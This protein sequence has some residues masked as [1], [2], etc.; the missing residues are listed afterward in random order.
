MA[1]DEGEGGEPE[2]LK[3]HLD[4]AQLET[5][6]E[7]TLAKLAG[8]MGL[9]VAGLKTKE[10]LVAAISGEEVYAPA[11]TDEDVDLSK[12]TVD[13]LREY[14][15]ENGISLTGCGTKS[16]ILQKINEFEADARAAAEVLQ[17]S[18]DD[19]QNS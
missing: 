8:E 2:T 18:G 11:A 14:A 5:M 1:T 19:P 13:K 16:E 6:S 4:P 9:D 3:G 12:M 15:K 17:Q 10:E 7:E